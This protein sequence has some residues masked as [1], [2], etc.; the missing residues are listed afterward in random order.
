MFQGF[1]SKIMRD[2]SVDKYRKTRADRRVPSELIVSLD[3]LSECIGGGAPVEPDDAVTEISR[4]LND[5]LKA[6]HERDRFV[7]VCRYYY[8]DSVAYIAKM[9]NIS[10]K[11]VYRDLQRIREELREVLNKEGIS[12]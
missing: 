9:A 4:I 11:T 1:L 6:L 3:E 10:D 8:S 7:F 12:L 2:I 5:F